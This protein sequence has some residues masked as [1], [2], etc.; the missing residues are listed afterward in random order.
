LPQTSVSKQRSQQNKNKTKSPATNASRILRS[1]F[2]ALSEATRSGSDRL[3]S[4]ALAEDLLAD[5]RSPNKENHGFFD[6]G[7]ATPPP[8][9]PPLP[10]PSPAPTP[11]VEP[12][13]VEAPLQLLLP[14]VVPL[15]LPLPAARVGLW[16]FPSEPDTPVLVV[17]G[18]QYPSAKPYGLHI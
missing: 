2:F 13:V 15:P 5:E 9:P 10:S 6:V 17:K 1:S 3:G 14:A 16:G 7:G 12:T 4:A 8:P 18:G 11:P